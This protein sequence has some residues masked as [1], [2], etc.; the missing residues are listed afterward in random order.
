MNSHKGVDRSR[1]I[2]TR[3]HELDSD[4]IID[5][6]LKRCVGTC[7]RIREENNITVDPRKRGNGGYTIQIND[8]KKK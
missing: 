8:K 6:P 2:C 3:N 5:S 7:K 1:T 4:G